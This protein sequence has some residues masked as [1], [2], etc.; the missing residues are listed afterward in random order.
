MKRQ[1]HRN[2]DFVTAK[3]WVYVTAIWN[4][5]RRKYNNAHD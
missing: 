3:D 1:G 2:H 5:A 4:L